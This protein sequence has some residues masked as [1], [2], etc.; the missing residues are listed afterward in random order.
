MSQSISDLSVKSDI[1]WKGLSA[2]LLPAII[3][4]NSIS[5]DVA[6]LKSRVEQAESSIQTI[7]TNLTEVS[8]TTTQ[9]AAKLEAIQAVLVKIDKDITDTRADLRVLNTRLLNLGY[10]ED[11]RQR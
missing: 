10:G 7:N 6:V 2:C 3:W 4:V 8:K 11:P 1:F 9:N 5:N